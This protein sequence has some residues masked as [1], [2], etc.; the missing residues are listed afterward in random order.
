[1][2]NYMRDRLIDLLQTADLMAFGEPKSWAEI[3]AD[4]LLE[5]GVI[6]PPCKVGDTVYTTLCY[7]IRDWRIEESVIVEIRKR[8]GFNLE[9]IERI[10]NDKGHCTYLPVALENFGVT[11]FLTKEEAENALRGGMSDEKL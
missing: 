7:G 9:I 6:L 5:N 11:K 8:L 1:M 10:T 2:P 3:L 4:Y